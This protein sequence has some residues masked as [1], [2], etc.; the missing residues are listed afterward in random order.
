M[1]TRFKNRVMATSFLLASFGVIS[2]ENVHQAPRATAEEV[3]MDFWDMPSLDKAFINNTPEQLTDTIK[4]GKLG[5]DGGNKTPILTLAKEL[6]ENKHGKYDSLLISHKGKLLFESYYKR[7]RIDLPHF[8]YSATKGYTSLMLA[9]AIELGHITMADLH[10]P[11]VSFFDDL[12]TSK[13]SVG[14]GQVTLHH[15]LSMRS[16]LR[17]SDEQLKDFREKRE[18]Y[19]GIAEVQAFL[20]LTEPVTKESQ[21]FK[22][23]GVDPILVM[24]VINS[25][26][27][28]S[29][30]E[31]VEKEFFNK[32]GIVDYKWALDPKGLLVAD[33]GV[34]LTS[35]DMLKI[36]EMLANQ[37][38]WQGKHLLSKEYLA[39]AFSPITN[40]TESW[41][42]EN[43]SY[44]YLWYQTNI[45]SDNKNYDINL[46]WGAGGNRVIVV[47]QLDLVIVITG[48]DRE[49]K[50]FEPL[51]DAILPAFTKG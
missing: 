6:A 28:G 15:A 24:H 1:F 5:I 36:G 20:E 8:Q 19:S 3:K 14:A 10:K 40:A 51:V 30:K 2:A 49:D 11:I 35:R 44:G 12:D 9:R 17:F 16:G 48:Y 47:H 25:V 18:K 31:F 37:G 4:V 13:L 7:G 41:H 34:D 50:V 27:P 38:K 45:A 21:V 43:F 42:P 33:S 46:T 29:A 32:M 39:A 22:Y 23:Q 26:V